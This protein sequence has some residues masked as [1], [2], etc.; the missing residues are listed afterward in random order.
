MG[1]AGWKQK[2]GN[3][4]EKEN[5]RFAVECLEKF[6]SQTLTRYKEWVGFSTGWTGKE[7]TEWERFKKDDR[8]KKITLFSIE[9]IDQAINELTKE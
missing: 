6:K 2:L 7:P 3:F 8:H 1:T 4:I 5:K 9:D